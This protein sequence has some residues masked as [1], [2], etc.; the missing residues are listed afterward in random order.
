MTRVRLQG[1]PQRKAEKCETVTEARK[2][3]A[4]NKITIVHTYSEQVQKLYQIV[5]TAIACQQAVPDLYIIYEDLSKDKHGALTATGVTA[6]LN[7]LVMV[8]KFKEAVQ[9]KENIILKPRCRIF[10]P[11]KCLEMQCVACEKWKPRTTLY[12]AAGHGGKNL[13]TSK[14]G[15][16]SLQNSA[17][18]P[19]S[20]CCAKKMTPN[21]RI[22]SLLNKYD[23]ISRA[24]F[25]AKLLENN[26][27]CF[28]TNTLLTTDGTWRFSIHNLD[29]K[30]KSHQ[31]WNIGCQRLNVPQ[32]DAIPCLMAA[33]DDMFQIVAGGN[34]HTAAVD[35]FANLGNTPVQNGVIA[36]SRTDHKLYLKQ[37]NSYNL[38][39]ILG[40]SIS[41]HV[42]GDKKQGRLTAAQV[43]AFRVW[44][45]SNRTQFYNSIVTKMAHEQHGKCAVSGVPLSIYNNHR[46]FSMDRVDNSKAHFGPQGE[47][48]NIRFICRIFNTRR[49]W[50]RS[51][52]LEALL[53][54]IR[55]PLNAEVRAAAVLELAEIKAASFCVTGV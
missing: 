25:D 19:C 54:Q 12:F 29:N 35:M 20:A 33:I 6:V 48:D 50:T 46:R 27:R 2:R 22:R 30:D 45:E 21:G 51:L 18:N 31:K 37:M 34:T 28:L 1:K 9:K 3:V 38:R 4:G 16:E 36:P 24:D 47:L 43:S 44:L 49:G 15:R 14:P 13:V 40:V 5:T 17:S 55:V 52:F 41:S 11:G 7:H 42:N 53:T 39:T 26:G 10:Q 8:V 23:N 32:H